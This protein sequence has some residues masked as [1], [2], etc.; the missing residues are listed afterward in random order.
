MNFIIIIFII[1]VFDI[2]W[3]EAFEILD[4]TFF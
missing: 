3:F 1:A 4:V 2:V